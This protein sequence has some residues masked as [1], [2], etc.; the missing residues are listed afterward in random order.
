MLELTELVSNCPAD[1]QERQM[2][3]FFPAVALPKRV[4]A[5]AIAIVFAGWLWLASAAEPKTEV[6]PEQI[7]AAKKHADFATLA[8]ARTVVIGKIRVQI[9]G[10]DE[11][12]PPVYHLKMIVTPTEVIAGAA[13]VGKPFAVRFTRRGEEEPEFA[14]AAYLIAVGTEDDPTALLLLK[15]V[16][17][18]LAE[19]AKVATVY[20][21]EQRAKHQALAR[22]NPEMHPLFEQLQKA[23]HLAV[24]FLSNDPDSVVSFDVHER[25][26]EQYNVTVAH[27]LRGGLKTGKLG[28]LAFT[29][30]ASPRGSRE[31]LL[32]VVEF[33][34]KRPVVV[35]TIP[36]GE[37]ELRVAAAV[38]EIDAGKLLED[39]ESSLQERQRAQAAART[40]GIFRGI[41]GGSAGSS[42]PSEGASTPS[43]DGGVPSTEEFEEAVP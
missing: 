34:D 35:R 18:H 33:R 25:L 5:P 2:K 17:D 23:K 24:L 1:L 36:A 43:F 14:D 27:S 12:F 39:I 32:V 10:V 38:A 15:P 20:G 29:E 6:T 41:F 7:E 26:E 37:E 31:T 4:V 19:I 28:R 11:I 9:N 13:E 8:S 22:N 40:R 30:D 3:H 16:E 42:E 21:A